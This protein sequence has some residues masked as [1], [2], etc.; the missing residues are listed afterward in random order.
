MGWLLG[1]DQLAG[2][3]LNLI[4]KKCGKE[5]SFQYEAKTFGKQE[6]KYSFTCCGNNINFNFYWS[7]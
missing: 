6:K 1:F 7:Y 3:Q 2:L 4:C 5:K